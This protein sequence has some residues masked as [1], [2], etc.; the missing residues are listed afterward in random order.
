MSV[1]NKQPANQ[2]TFNNAFVSRSAAQTVDGGK[3]F[4]KYIA[5]NKLDVTSASTINALASSVSF[6]KLTGSTATTLN[7]ITAGVNGQHIT[8]HNGSTQTMVV[9]HNSGAAAT[10]NKIKLPESSNVDVAP[11]SSIE[12]IY[13]LTAGFW[14]QKSGSGSGA[15]AGGSKN[16]FSQSK[17]NPDFKSGSVSPWTAFTTTLSSGVPT[18]ITETA[19]QM[20]ISVTTTT[21]LQGTHSLL[22][23]KS[24]ANAVGQGFISAPFTIDREDLAKSLTGSFYYELVS[25]TFDAS[26]SSTQS[27]E[28]WL[29]NVTGNYWIQPAGYRGIN[30]TSGAGRLVYTFQ[31]DATPANNQY[32][33]AVF[34]AQTSTSAFEM[35]FD[36]FVVSPTQL[37]LTPS[38]VQPVTITR[39]TSGSGT[40]NTPGGVKYLR[41]RMVGG[42]GGGGGGG[43]GGNTTFG[44]SLLTANGGAG[45]G[46]QAAQG[47]LGGSVTVNSP[48][49]AIV[50][51]SGGAGGGNAANGGGF[52]GTTPFGGGGGNGVGPLNIS[53]GRAGIVNTG[54]GGGGNGS[55]NSGFAGGGAGGYIDAIIN[56][57][58]ASYTYSVGTGG[59]GSNGGSGGSGVII[60]EEYYTAFGD[61]GG[62]VIDFSARGSANHALSGSTD[63][64]VVCATVERDSTGS[65]NPSTGEFT[66]PVS[67]D[68]FF[69]GSVINAIGGNGSNLS[70]YKNGVL[71]GQ[72]TQGTVLTNY[73]NCTMTRLVPCN[74]GDKITLRANCGSSST[75]LQGIY[76]IFSGFR[77]AGPSVIAASESV[78]ASYQLSSNLTPG[79]NTPINF[80]L[81]LW[82]SHNAVTTG[83]GTWRFTAPISGEYQVEGFCYFVGG[84]SDGLVLFFQ[85]TGYAVI[86]YSTNNAAVSANGVTSIKLKAGE[87]IDLRVSS[88]TTVIRG[89]NTGVPSDAGRVTIRRV[90]N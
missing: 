35:E 4:Q 6:I 24:A 77:M 89:N 85:G 1:Q 5:T 90:G 80:N 18:T 61:S 34:T 70:I 62:S 33:L 7:G 16:Y 65:Y 53:A 23:T 36:D 69:T 41:V 13:D 28:V 29:Y 54:S 88:G 21:P 78:S 60:I 40:Y 48:A 15:N 66:A 58:S 49:I 43:A 76:S 20:A 67:G 45:G 68:Y 57:P 64:T 26:G 73:A 75:S 83:V 59:S 44:T 37:T 52:G 17:I 47:G 82:D 19:T 3:E 38:A 11:D 31:T 25:G 14:V 46:G 63:V 50:A 22:L 51:N 32:R 86:S 55:S 12:F 74:A 27:L 9:T 8:V 42:G 71:Y 79:A 2:N 84:S 87:Y 56:N 81:K 39:L 10:G 30:Q 72:P